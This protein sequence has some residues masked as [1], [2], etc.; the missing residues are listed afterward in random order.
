MDSGMITQLY[1]TVSFTTPMYSL[2][3]HHIQAPYRRLTEL[4]DFYIFTNYRYDNNYG[5]RSNSNSF[6]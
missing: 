2:N 3:P 5:F 6:R 1:Q 4:N